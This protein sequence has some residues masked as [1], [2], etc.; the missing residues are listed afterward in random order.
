MSSMNPMYVSI[1]VIVL[2]Y[3]G[4]HLGLRIRKSLPEDHLSADTKE[5]VKLSAGLIATLTAL[6]LG[7]LV[8]SAKDTLD[9]MNR[10]LTQ[11]GAK[12]ILLDRTLAN[13]GPGTSE[14]RTQLRGHVAHTLK[15]IWNE[16]VPDDAALKAAEDPSGMESIQA[17]LRDLSP[18]SDSQRLLH[19]QAL[20][21]S[22]D[23]AMSRWLIV[24]S[25]QRAL[26]DA[27]LVVLSLWLMILYTCYGLIAPKNWTVRVVLFISALSIAG[28]IFLVL[29][30]NTPL[31]GII[32]VSSAPLHKALVHMGR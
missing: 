32:K 27:F 21:L 3:C 5:I 16:D 30:M 9:T 20:Q 18:H 12:I 29:E 28:A 11:D 6:V 15:L 13:Y 23:L 25:M 14:I 8:S 10:E 17:R 26:P 31:S 24:E 2:T 19:A 4:T 22:S 1:I 7:L